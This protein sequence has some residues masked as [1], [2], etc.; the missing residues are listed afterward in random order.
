M[1]KK[2]LRVIIPFMLEKAYEDIINND[3]IYKKI[4]KEKIK[5]I[6][7][8]QIK[9]KNIKVEDK[10]E[11]EREV[12]EY[13]RDLIEEND[14][15]ILCEDDEIPC[16]QPISS[17]EDEPT[18]LSSQMELP[19]SQMELPSSQISIPLLRRKA[20]NSTILQH[21]DPIIQL[22]NIEDYSKYTFVI[23][24][25]LKL[26]NNCGFFLVLNLM[27]IIKYIINFNSKCI[28]SNNKLQINS[29]MYCFYPEDFRNIIHN[30]LIEFYKLDEYSKSN[31]IDCFKS[32]IQNKINII[33]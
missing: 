28:V 20:S 19:S 26:N 31:L 7:K 18:P 10:K 21:L 25:Q 27:V 8:N 6:K 29:E 33:Y 1:V 14:D 5:E 22:F 30:P 24:E 9:E 2:K 32:Q 13:E 16:G 23:Q 4:K 3:Y 15:E 12:S 11:N 17:E